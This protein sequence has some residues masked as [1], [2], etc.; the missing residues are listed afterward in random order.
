ILEV[1]GQ[2]A[3]AF[4]NRRLRHAV[5]AEVGS[6]PVER[7]FAG[8][9]KAGPGD[10]MGAAALPADGPVEEGQVAA[11]T[12]QPVGIKQ[13]VSRDVVLVDGLLDQAEAEY[14]PVEGEIPRR[15]GGHGGEMV[16]TGEL[17]GSH[18]RGARPP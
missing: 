16:D 8:Y 2:P 18:S 11:G 12:G 17:H 10:R 1:E 5:L 4:G 14:I 7:G 9:A 3:V 15:V 13:V 6:P